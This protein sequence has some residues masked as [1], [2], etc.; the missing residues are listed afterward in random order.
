MIKR[1]MLITVMF[2]LFGIGSWLL[3]PLS[4]VAS[5]ADHWCIQR[6]NDARKECLAEEDSR[7]Q[8]IQ[9]RCASLPPAEQRECYAREQAR[10]QE[11]HEDCIEASQDCKQ[12]CHD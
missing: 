9:A 7:H 12:D 3:L 2:G 4:V 8:V 1:F 5:R 10:H 6:C 11:A